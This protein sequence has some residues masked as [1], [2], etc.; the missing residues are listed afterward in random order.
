MLITRFL[1][2][3]FSFSLPFHVPCFSHFLP[4]SPIFQKNVIVQQQS[5]EPSGNFT[6]FS[7]MFWETNSPP[8]R[9]PS[10]ASNILRKQQ[11]MGEMVNE[12]CLMPNFI[13]HWFCVL[14]VFYFPHIFFPSYKHESNIKLPF[15]WFWAHTSTRQHQDLPPNRL[16]PYYKG[17]AY[18]PHHSFTRI[19]NTQLPLPPPDGRT[20]ITGQKSILKA[21][22]TFTFRWTIYL[23]RNTC[24]LLFL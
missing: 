23:R 16:Y 17:E 20:P 12:M 7:G 14:V 19:L 13:V 22:D 18:N 2:F 9:Q 11:K 5:P 8:T 4:F 21:L 1:P 15:L 24:F 10:N 6:R 3:S